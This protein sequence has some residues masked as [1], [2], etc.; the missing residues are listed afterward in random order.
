MNVEKVGPCHCSGPE[1]EKIFKD[2][3]KDKFV[4]MKAGISI[5]V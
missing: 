4:S 1:A 5:I 3:Y 2:E